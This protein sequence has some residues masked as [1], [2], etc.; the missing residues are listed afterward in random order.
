MRGSLSPFLELTVQDSANPT[1]TRPEP[2]PF[3]RSRARC[4]ETGARVVPARQAGLAG[5]ALHRAPERAAIRLVTDVR[6]VNAE[7]LSLLLGI[8]FKRTWPTLHKLPELEPFLSRARVW[9]NW[10]QII[11]GRARVGL[12]EARRRTGLRSYKAL[13]PVTGVNAAVPGLVS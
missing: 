10:G 7:P 11:P 3:S 9:R 8:D 1:Q 2:E 12:S 4:G 6:L 5:E 13:R